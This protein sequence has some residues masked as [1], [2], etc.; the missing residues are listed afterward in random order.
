MV[1]LSTEMG[2]TF[3]RHEDRLVLEA[4]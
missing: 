2:T 4:G 1:G 3:H